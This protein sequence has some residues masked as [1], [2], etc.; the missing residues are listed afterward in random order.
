M[1]RSTFGGRVT[2]CG[3]ARKASSLPTTRGEVSSTS[4]PSTLSRALSAASTLRTQSDRDPYTST[5]R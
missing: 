4:F 3:R 2:S 5:N 1:I